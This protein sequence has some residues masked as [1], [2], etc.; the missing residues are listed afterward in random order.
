M[1]KKTTITRKNKDIIK[2]IKLAILN[3]EKNLNY[4]NILKV[5]KIKYLR[6]IKIV[7]FHTKKLNIIFYLEVLKATFA[8]DTSLEQRNVIRNKIKEEIILFQ[9]YTEKS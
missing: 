4:T 8:N 6:M 9:K 7:T 2:F 5:T 3:F 1:D